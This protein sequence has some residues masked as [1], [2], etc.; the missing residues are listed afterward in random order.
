MAPQPDGKRF[1]SEQ[2]LNEIADEIDR[3]I[4]VP[5]NAMVEADHMVYDFSEVKAIL[6][7]ARKIVV[8]D[9]GCRTEYG[10]CDSGKVLGKYPLRRLLMCSGGATRLGWFTWLML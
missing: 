3:A 7:K 10:N 5:V 9:C 2:Q 8:E 4:T 1:Y 6:S